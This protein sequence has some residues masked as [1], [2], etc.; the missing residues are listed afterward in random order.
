M[1]KKRGFTLVE[2]LVVIAIIA[3][4][5]AMLLPALAKAR[6]AA[7]ASNCRAN[8][9]QMGIGIFMYT[10]ANSEWFPP[11]RGGTWNENLMNCYHQAIAGYLEI[12]HAMGR[13]PNDDN[14]GS[15]G[16]GRYQLMAYGPYTCPVDQGRTW[17]AFSYGQNPYANYFDAVNTTVA[18]DPYGTFDL[19]TPGGTAI[20]NTIRKLSQ[21]INPSSAIAMGDSYDG[22]TTGSL[23]PGN[24]GS[25][26]TQAEY[27]VYFGENTRG[28]AMET[29]DLVTQMKMDVERVDWRHPDNTANFIFMDG[30]VS[31]MKWDVTVGPGPA[32][33]SYAGD[34]NTRGWLNGLDVQ[35]HDV[36]KT[37]TED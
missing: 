24:M 23:V 22:T 18:N 6:Q 2:L 1:H 27:L 20:T 31:A 36:W 34:A 37:G 3:I 21:V 7:W 17:R 32:G 4:L 9:K 16:D 19:P 12:G 35:V 13:T 14:Y 28:F 15:L 5:A 11:G 29:K 33:V 26:G 10:N 30:H 25:K 8:L